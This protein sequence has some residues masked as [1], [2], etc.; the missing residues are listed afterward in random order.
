MPHG[1]S[2]GGSTFTPYLAAEYDALD[3]LQNETAATLTKAGQQ[4]LIMVRSSLPAGISQ[5]TDSFATNSV[6]QL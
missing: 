1:R 6:W 4:D 3:N 5:P 2:A